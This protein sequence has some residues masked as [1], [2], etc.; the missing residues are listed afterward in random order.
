M[1]NFRRSRTKKLTYMQRLRSS[2]LTWGIPMLCLAIIG[3]PIHAWW[4]VLLF[5]VPGVIVAVVIGAWI[6]HLVVRAIP[7]A[8]DGKQQ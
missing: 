4:V 7:Y 8:P 3:V 2:A 1:L 5:E 6:E